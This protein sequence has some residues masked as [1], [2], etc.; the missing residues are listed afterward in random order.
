[1]ST[2]GADRFLGPTPKSRKAVVLA[3]LFGS[4][5]ALAWIEFDE[6]WTR[7]KLNHYV[8]SIGGRIEV[9]DI[10][11]HDVNPFNLQYVI[12]APERDLTTE[13][14]EKL[15]AFAKY[16]HLNRIYK[17]HEVVLF[18]FPKGQPTARFYKR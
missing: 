5:I 6:F 11:R 4:L 12:F 8:K 13:E 9:F 17:Q 15:E 16:L 18:T 1:M 7:R 2:E 10:R 14:Q 3:C